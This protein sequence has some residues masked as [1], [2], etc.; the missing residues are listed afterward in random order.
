MV[1]LLGIVVGTEIP[2]YKGIGFSP[3]DKLI[4]G[5]GTDVEGTES[6][7]GGASSTSFGVRVWGTGETVG[8]IGSRGKGNDRGEEAL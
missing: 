4:G 2:L 6:F 3:T 7:I 5:I 8:T 1:R